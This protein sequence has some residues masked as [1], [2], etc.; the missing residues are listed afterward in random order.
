VT[1]VVAP[2]MRG[3]IA[4]ICNRVHTVVTPGKTVDVLVTDQGIAVNPLRPELEEKLK[5]AGLPVVT[6]RELQEKAQKVTGKPHEIKV[7]D[8][9]V[10]VVNYRDGSVID[11]IYQVS[12]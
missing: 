5:R 2:L 11:V 9:I 6:M 7:K 12:R 10:G 4:T 8:R 1:I 3:R